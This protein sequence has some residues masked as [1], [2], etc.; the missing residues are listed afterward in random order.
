MVDSY[1]IFRALLKNHQLQSRFFVWLFLSHFHSLGHFYRWKQQTRRRSRWRRS[2][3]R[4]DVPSHSRSF[5]SRTGSLCRIPCA[6]WWSIDEWLQWALSWSDACALQVW[7]TA[8]DHKSLH[9]LCPCRNYLWNHRSMVSVC[10]RSGRTNA[11]HSSGSWDQFGSILSYDCII[12]SLF[13][14]F[15]LSW[16]A[17]PLFWRIWSIRTGKSMRAIYLFSILRIFFVFIPCS[18]DDRVLSEYTFSTTVWEGNQYKEIPLIDNGQ[19][20]VVTNQNKHI[21]IQ[22]LYQYQLYQSIY[23][24]CNSFYQGILDALQFNLFSLLSPVSASCRRKMNIDVCTIDSLWRSTFFR[25]GKFKKIFGIC[26]FFSSDDN[27][28]WW[29]GWRELPCL[30][31]RRTGSWAIPNGV[32]ECSPLV[33]GG[34]HFELDLMD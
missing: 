3:S 9:S 15:S 23:L 6:L 12:L 29:F 7:R 31:L 34:M 32:V 27:W 28:I 2:L 1:G 26:L 30:D 16:V 33:L 13:F 5:F 24:Y 17:N 20:T 25:F 22:K 8:G 19:T 4:A 14:I 21:Y 10:W 11:T 18:R